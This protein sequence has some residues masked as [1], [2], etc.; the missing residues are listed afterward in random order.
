[1]AQG[2]QNALRGPQ[3]TVKQTSWSFWRCWEIFLGCFSLGCSRWSVGS[4]RFVLAL[5]KKIRLR[6][7]GFQLGV[8]LRPSIS[9]SSNLQDA[10][11][12]LGGCLLKGGFAATASCSPGKPGNQ[13]RTWCWKQ[14]I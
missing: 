11:V 5:H 9:T 2:I 14:A 3:L 10:I 13:R 4:C 1:M 7:S 8:L 6:L 12:F